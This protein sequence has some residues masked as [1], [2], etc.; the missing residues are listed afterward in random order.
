[1]ETEHSCA[2]CGENFK[3][4][5][6]LVLHLRRKKVC[7]ATV[8]DVS[9]DSLIET[10]TTKHYND[11]TYDCEF[12]GTRFNLSS[13]KSRHRKNCKENPKNKSTDMTE[14]SSITPSSKSPAVIP[15][16]TES[17]VDSKFDITN[18]SYVMIE[19]VAL[20]HMMQK[21]DH[22]ERKLEALSSSKT[23][24]TNINNN[25]GTYNINI[26]LNNFGQENVD[27]LTDEFL[28]NCLFNPKKGM[29]SL[30]ETIHYNKDLPQNQNLRCKSLDP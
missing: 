23:N 7:A 3:R 9:R 4:K 29:T 24:I 15:A 2:R 14:E 5:E 26:Q 19:K 18:Q 28:S 8:K 21:L 30:I 1:M 13:C 10:L 17:T 20:E 12:C 25:N 6:N 22:F 16:L 27:H 11:K